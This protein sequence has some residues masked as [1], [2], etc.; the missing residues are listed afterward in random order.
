MKKARS[1]SFGLCVAFALG[2]GSG[3]TLFSGCPNGVDAQS[4][5]V[6]QLTVGER[7]VFRANG[8]SE[9]GAVVRMGPGEWV[10]LDGGLWVNLGE[11]FRVYSAN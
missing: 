10:E 5:P 8:E 1:V 6:P 7:Y 2:L 3:I 11:T 4:D 9:S